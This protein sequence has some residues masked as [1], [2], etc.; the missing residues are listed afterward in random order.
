MFVPPIV[1]M[2]PSDVL[3]APASTEMHLQL[4]SPS[5]GAVGAAVG[6]AVGSTVGA[7]V[8]AG[9]GSAVGS[10]V[11][12][13]VGAGVGSAVGSAVGAG[14]GAGVGSAVGSTVGTGVGAGV[15][16]TVGSAVGAGVGAE[17]GG[18]AKL[19]MPAKTKLRPLLP[20]VTLNLIFHMLLSSY[21]TV[22]ARPIC[23]SVRSYGYFGFGI[24]CPCSSLA[25]WKVRPYESDPDCCNVC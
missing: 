15:G 18:A 25:D 19:D 3:L 2:T 6:S 16:D 23:C 4:S 21:R 9:V 8:G 14:V 11:G 5:L 12:A 7:G 17:V 13:G 10:A 22:T 1:T 24:P 20:P